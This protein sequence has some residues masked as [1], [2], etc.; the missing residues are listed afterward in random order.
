ML[1]I[2]RL[3]IALFYVS[4]SFAAAASQE[5]TLP[6]SEFRLETT[7]S[8]PSGR[9]LISGSQR[10]P[11]FTRLEAEA[12]GKH[13]SLTSMQLQQLKGFS[14]NGVQ[15]VQISP[16]HSSGGGK[17]YLV[18]TRGALSEKLERRFVVF[19]AEGKVGVGSSP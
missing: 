19:T 3:L 14:A 6:L 4:V 7:D 11:H 18:L 12:F 8:P 13:F 2:A 15:L 1:G 9:V 16:G 5:G 17:V 10:F